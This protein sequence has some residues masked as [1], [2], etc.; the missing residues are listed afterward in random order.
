MDDAPIEVVPDS[1]LTDLI[2]KD[3]DLLQDGNESQNQE[4]LIQFD[5]IESTQLEEKEVI[6]QDLLD[7]APEEPS[8]DI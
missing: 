6:Q 7:F 8:P 1:A 5:A 4:S 3:I 2:S